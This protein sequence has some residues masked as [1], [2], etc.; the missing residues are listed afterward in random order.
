LE[1]TVSKRKLNITLLVFL[2]INILPLTYFLIKGLLL[3]WNIYS[4][5]QHNDLAK[6][7]L[8]EEEENGVVIKYNGFLKSITDLDYD[9]L[10][11]ELSKFFG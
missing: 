8:L 5:D 9:G 11:K 7:S 6:M 4:I 10:V 1:V 3:D 2:V